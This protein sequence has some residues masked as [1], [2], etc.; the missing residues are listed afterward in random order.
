MTSQLKISLDGHREFVGRCGDFLLDT[1]LR[2]GIELP[3]DCRSGYCGSCTVSLE[4]GLTFGGETGCAGQVRACQAR[5]FS[6]LAIRVEPTPQVTTIAGEIETIET[7]AKDTVSVSIQTKRATDILPGQ[8]CRVDFKR[9]GVRSFSP[10]ADMKTGLFDP[11]RLRFHIKKVSGGRVTPA[12]GQAIGIGH[13]VRVSGPFGHAFH[14]MG[15][16]NR[17]VLV[18]TGTGFA[19]IWAIAAAALAESPSR[20]IILVT[21]TRSATS[22]YMV[23]ALRL[24]GSYR[25]VRVRPFVE[26]LP[27]HVPAIYRGGWTDRMPTLEPDDIV[28]AAGGPAIVDAVRARADQ[29]DATFYSDPFHAS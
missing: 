23:P 10:T 26:N 14:R 22:F 7:I 2:H 15:R 4:K 6:D 25:N 9:F 21:G 11:W 5:M 16:D 17:L 20:E 13:K 1:A 19:P 8:Y 3:H 28:Y 29:A 18:G 12:L 24:A 27:S